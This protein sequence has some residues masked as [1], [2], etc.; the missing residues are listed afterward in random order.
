MVI[1]LMELWI[2][3]KKLMSKIY[4]IICCFFFLIFMNYSSDYNKLNMYVRTHTHARTHSHRYV[5]PAH[6][7][8]SPPSVTHTH[9]HSLVGY[10]TYFGLT[11]EGEVLLALQCTLTF[12]KLHSLTVYKTVELTVRACQYE[13]ARQTERCIA[14]AALLLR[15]TESERVSEWVSKH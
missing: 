2:S 10:L 13:R 12:S 8:K 11:F 5:L 14:A 9:T 6:K 7:N 15:H 1:K 3:N 4:E